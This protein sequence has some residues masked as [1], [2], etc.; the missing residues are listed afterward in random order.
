MFIFAVGGLNDGLASGIVASSRQ[1]LKPAFVDQLSTP[2]ADAVGA[3][4]DSQERLINV[5][6]HLRFALTQTQRQLL[7]NIH[8]REVDGIFY[9]V[10]GK[11]ERVRL[12]LANV[13]GMF[14]KL[15]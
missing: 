14:T 3:F 4:L 13:F 6:N 12:I 8:H 11:L 5:G 15:S 10:V 2:G 1:S 9:V 7:V